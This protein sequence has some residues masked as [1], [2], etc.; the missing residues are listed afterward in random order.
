M[1]IR[2]L[3]SLPLILEWPND[4][5]GWTW[6]KPSKLWKH[7]RYHKVKRSKRSVN[8]NADKCTFSSGKNQFLEVKSSSK[9]GRIAAQENLDVKKHDNLK[10]SCSFRRSAPK[11][12]PKVS[13]FKNSIKFADVFAHAV[14][15]RLWFE[16]MLWTNRQRSYLLKNFIQKLRS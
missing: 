6:Q 10:A 4:L 5:I 7:Q 14:V 16:L 1:Q 11:L 13:L 8:L 9:P 12:N 15:S 2:C 3:L